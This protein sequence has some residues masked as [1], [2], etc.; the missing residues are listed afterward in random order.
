MVDTSDRL[1]RSLF[2]LLLIF[3]LIL[4]GC[5]GAP[6]TSGD[7]PGVTE[8]APSPLASLEPPPLPTN[9]PAPG[10]IALVAQPG[11]GAEYAGEVNA[12]LSELAA[13]SGLLFEQIEIQSESDLESV[14][15]VFW[16][17]DASSFAQLAASS[18]EIPFVL[19]GSEEVPSGAN[20]SQIR[21][22]PLRASFVAGLITILIASDR[23]AG[24]L[25]PADDPLNSQLTDAFVNGARYLCGNCAPIYAPLVFFPLTGAVAGGGGFDA[26]KAAFDQMDQ[27]RVEAL[28]LASEG[29]TSEMLDY[30]K[31]QSVV[32]VGSA[33]PPEGYAALWAATVTLD[34]AVA[35]EDI[36]AALSPPDA[37]AQVVDAPVV[38][39]DVNESILSPGKLQLVE[40]ITAE[41]EAGLISPLS[42]P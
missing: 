19:I 7:Q 41:L 9:T 39:R 8:T 11:A 4:A 20:V 28:Y 16:I 29:V 14:R 31:S 23:R 22:S 13:Q 25:F 26:W 15:A 32:V 42:V 18:P 6:A 36:W 5:N 24:G 40:K 3:A 35:L 10:K 21:L 1:P 12:R 38:V 34:P 2:I 37:G 30:L 27:S 17:G 33:A